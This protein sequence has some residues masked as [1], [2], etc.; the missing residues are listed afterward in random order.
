MGHIEDG[1]L[2][3]CQS[4]VH[5]RIPPCSRVP[6]SAPPGRT[7]S[8]DAPVVPATR[9]LWPWKVSMMAIKQFLFGNFAAIMF[10]AD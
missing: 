8:I 3:L 1:L 6:S 9:R 4:E 7:V 2:F 5:G 10:E